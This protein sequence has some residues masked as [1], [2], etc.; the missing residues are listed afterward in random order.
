MSP[1]V[2]KMLDAKTKAYFAGTEEKR[3]I[4]TRRWTSIAARQ[5]TR[6][7]YGSPAGKGIRRM[8]AIER[9]DD[10]RFARFSDSDQ[11]S[12]AMCALWAEW[13]SAQVGRRVQWGDIPQHCRPVRT[14]PKMDIA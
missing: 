4:E 14:L 10:P 13:K 6:E 8:I 5:D 11:R 1:K 2:W 9:G 3:A 7:A 12:I